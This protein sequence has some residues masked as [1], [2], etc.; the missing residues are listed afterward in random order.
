M[1]PLGCNECNAGAVLGGL[2]R[3]QNECPQRKRKGIPQVC[4]RARRLDASPCS[5]KAEADFPS[6]RVRRVVEY[7]SRFNKKNTAGGPR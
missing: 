6:R 7:H 4:R 2:R 3:C 1:L 5:S